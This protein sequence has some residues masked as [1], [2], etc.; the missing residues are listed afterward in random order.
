MLCDSNCM[1]NRDIYFEINEVNEN[2]KKAKYGT[3]EKP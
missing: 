1:F 2:D 3:N